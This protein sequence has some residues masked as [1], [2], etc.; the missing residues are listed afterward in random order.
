MCFK[1]KDYL[2]IKKSGC[3]DARYYL[4][5]NPDVRRAD[6]DPLMHFLKYG[7]KEGRSPSRQMEYLS[8]APE[9][10]NKVENNPVIQFIKQ[11]REVQKKSNPGL[12]KNLRFFFKGIIF[13]LSLKGVVIFG[14]YPYQER[15]SDGYYQR[16]RSIDS[17]FSDKWRVYI[18]RVFLP[19][20]SFWYDFPA[21]RTLI[22]RVSNSQGQN[23]L[24]RISMVLAIIRTRKIYS[25]SILAVD[26][27]EFLFRVP[28]IKKIIDVH[29]VVPEEF[30]YQG[31]EHSAQHFDEI[32][33][34]II[35][36]ADTIIVV[37]EQMRHHLESKY[38]GK[39]KGKFI[40]L[41]IIQDILPVVSGNLPNHEKPVIVY[42]GGTQKWQQVPK[43]VDAMV[44]TGTQ[45][46]YRFYCPDPERLRAMLPESLRDSQSLEIGSKTPE[47]ILQVYRECQYG[48]VLREDIIVNQV[49]CP[50]KLMEYL[51]S[52][53]VPIVESE[54]IGD[55]KRMG[56][57]YV[58]LS[59]L[60]N[61]QLPV[62]SIRQSM[63]KK[64]IDIYNQL[65]EKY[66]TGIKSLQQILH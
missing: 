60:L 18:D 25:H 30:R 11:E 52:G 42:A 24:A 47:E 36:N 29:G 37:S 5:N 43:M 49:A 9:N 57:K 13:F 7:W 62:E 61:F 8:I 19:G 26:G 64:N 22:L 44:R 50:T 14:G 59:E 40:F 28:G 15:E 41:P 46:E 23:T 55:F 54:N 58:R 45:Y 38:P 53:I 3:F 12:I 10:R 48:F 51:A 31:E 27:L 35:K 63:A 56:M 21:P 1:N 34:V 66:H 33:R 2:L 39:I 32:E 17:L 20:R 4:A 6:I 16:I 65:L